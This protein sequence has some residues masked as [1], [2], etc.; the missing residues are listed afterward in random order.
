MKRASTWLGPGALPS[1][2][3]RADCRVLHGVL[4]DLG[5]GP[6]RD[7][8]HVAAG[9]RLEAGEVHRA[10]VIQFPPEGATREHHVVGLCEERLGIR[11]PHVPEAR[12]ARGLYLYGPPHGFP[13][14][15]DVLGVVAS[16]LFDGAL[17]VSR[18]E[19]AQVADVLFEG[20]CLP[21]Q[22]LL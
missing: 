12:R 4:L 2:L 9:D 22:L 8:G 16:E 15:G 7:P 6:L 10:F 18:Q 17:V 11:D 3:S 14:L 20:G 5:P 21:L 19:C 1:A 13:P